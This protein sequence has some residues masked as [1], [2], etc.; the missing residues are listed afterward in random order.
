MGLCLHHVP[1]GAGDILLATF[2]AGGAD[3][4][5]LPGAVS[6][7]AASVP[8]EGT[9]IPTP[10]QAANVKVKVNKDLEQNRAL[11]EVN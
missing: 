8:L 7:S 3:V 1:V 2:I 11:V 5:A 10:S 9:A 4:E 6:W